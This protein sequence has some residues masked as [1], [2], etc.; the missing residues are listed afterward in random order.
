MFPTLRSLTLIANAYWH[1]KLW[2]SDGMLPYR[3][4]WDYSKLFSFSFSLDEYVRQPRLTQIR[5][6]PEGKWCVVRRS[7]DVSVGLTS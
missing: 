1:C 7:R 4:I 5:I 2:P 6:V 3:G